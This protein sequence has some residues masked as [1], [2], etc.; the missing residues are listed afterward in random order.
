MRLYYLTAEKW[1]KKVIEERRVK[2]SLFE[3]LNDPFELSPHVLPTQEHRRVAKVLR[4]HLS[5][6]RGVICFSTQWHSPVMWAHYG[7][8][9][10]GMCLGFDV[11]DELAMRVSYKTKRLSFDVD[12]T[13]RNAGV[14]PEMVKAMLLTKFEAWRYEREYRVMA[15]LQDRDEDGRYYA[16]F[17]EQ[18]TLREAIIGARCETSQ[19]YVAT[20]VGNLESEVKIRKA[21]LAF[22]DFKIVDQREL[23][24]LLAGKSLNGG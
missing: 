4:E 5:K 7:D 6:Q 20:W 22:K 9:H 12:L 1:A 24:V 3:E 2:I 11:P 8:K 15:D 10:Y 13:A 16:K 19:Q 23:P 21:R 14:T 17:G 18:M